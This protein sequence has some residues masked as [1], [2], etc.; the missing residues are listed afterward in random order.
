M[1]KKKGSGFL[2]LGLGLGVGALLLWPKK[3]KAQ[4]KLTVGVPTVGP[5]NQPDYQISK[6]FKHSEMAQSS[7]LPGIA[8]HVMS[9]QEKQNE[10]NLVNLQLQP[11]RDR[12][13]LPVI[14]TSGGRPLD[15]KTTTAV[16]LTTLDGKQIV[17]PAGQTIDDL[18]KAKGYSPAVD[19]D[20]HYWG[21]V[22]FVFPK[23]T[24]AGVYTDAYSFLKGLD[25]TRQVILYT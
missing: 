14:I 25:S 19:S 2:I 5:G 6:N 20:H 22:D 21:G 10:A 9:A 4:V 13:G 11:V 8:G 24:D 17:L 23:G 15:V 12:E 3:S 7:T 18:L 16:T 1:S